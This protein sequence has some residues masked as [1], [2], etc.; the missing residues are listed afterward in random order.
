MELVALSCF[1][2]AGTT[3][4]LRVS[5]YDSFIRESTTDVPEPGT[6]ILLASA[7]G[8][9]GPFAFFLVRRRRN[10]VK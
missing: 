9:G 7:L 6:L 3:G 5:G 2:D 10:Q 1:I 4:G 8:G